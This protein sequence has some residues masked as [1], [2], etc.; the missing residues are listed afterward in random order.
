MSGRRGAEGGV[1]QGRGAGCSLCITDCMLLSKGTGGNLGRLRVRRDVLLARLQEVFPYRMMLIKDDPHGEEINKASPP[2]KPVRRTRVNG[3][4]TREALL[5]ASIAIWAERG[6]GAVTMH[7]V[8]ERAGRTRGTV[9][10]HFADRDELLRATKQHLEASLQD[11]FSDHREALGDPI[12]VVSGLV[13]ESPEMMRSMFRDM[14]DLGVR[15]NPLVSRAVRYFEA[16]HRQGIVRDGVD[17]RDA[18]LTVLSLWFGALLTVSLVAAPRARRESA[19][20]YK[21]LFREVVYG[22]LVNVPDEGGLPR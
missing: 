5:G 20:R 18:A 21:R 16:L 15:E 2:V 9:Y 4:S 10:H 13:A 1:R 11:L 22:S 17:P 3:D 8:G 19:Q 14:L 6:M 7:G 12:D